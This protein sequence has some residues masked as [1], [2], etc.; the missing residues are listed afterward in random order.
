MR[1]RQPIGHATGNL[2]RWNKSQDEIVSLFRKLDVDAIE[3]TFGSVEEL[4]NT[5]FSPSNQQYL[6]SLD[7]VSIHMPFRHTYKEDELTWSCVRKALAMADEIGASHF[8]IHHN[9]L[10]D[11]DVVQALLGSGRSVSFENLEAGKVPSLEAYDAALAAYPH[12]GMVLDTTHA[13]SHSR[14]H[15][16]T[17]LAWLENKKLDQVHLSTF[18]EK[19]HQPLYRDPALLERVQHL[20]VPIII[21]VEYQ[22]TDLDGPKKDYELAVATFRSRSRSCSSTR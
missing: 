19:R 21:E 11:K 3:L 13:Y 20:T 18:I 7:Y 1:H 14:E 6:R 8:T 12:V 15:L 4:L 2:F 22:P 16:D 10:I 5:S 17:L 9:Q